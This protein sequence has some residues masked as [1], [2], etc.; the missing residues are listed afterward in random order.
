MGHTT[1][2]RVWA[3]IDQGTTSTR[4]NLYDD[5]GTCV[6]S[7]RRTSHTAHPRPGWDEQDGNAMLAAIEETVREAVAS[8]PGAEL[9][10]IGLANQGESIIAFDRHTGQPLSPAILW[11]DRRAGPIVDS[12]LSTPS[13]ARIEDVTGLLSLIHI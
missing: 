8:V 7:A 11:S 10:G 4:T 5:S 6:A 12:V 2:V 1:P 13:A 9:A 3:G